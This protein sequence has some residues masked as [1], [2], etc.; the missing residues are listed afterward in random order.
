ML[1]VHRNKKPS[2]PPNTPYTTPAACLSQYLYIEH[3][4][5]TTKTEAISA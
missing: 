3:G 4:S 2:L 1:G 5:K